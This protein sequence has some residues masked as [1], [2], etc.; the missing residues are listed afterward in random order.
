MV[1][2]WYYA[3][4]MNKKIHYLYLITRRDGLRYVGVSINPMYRFKRHILGCGNIYLVGHSDASIKILSQGNREYI[5][6]LEREYIKQ[7]NPELNISEG[8]YGG[9]SGNAAKGEKNGHSKLLEKDIISIRERVFNGEPYKEIAKEYGVTYPTI[10]SACIGKTWKHVGGPISSFKPNKQQ[11]IDKVKELTSIG[12]SAKE[13][14]NTLSI[15]VNSVYRYRH[16]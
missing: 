1:I 15:S 5:Y 14:A 8:G 6:N 16:L 9:D 11:I 3:D 7:N 12:L 13:I 10:Y 4:V 2:F